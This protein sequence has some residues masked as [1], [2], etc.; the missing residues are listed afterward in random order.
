[1]SARGKEAGLHF[2]DMA[3]STVDAAAAPAALKIEAGPFS[4]VV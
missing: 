4:I 2:M 1:M 3:E